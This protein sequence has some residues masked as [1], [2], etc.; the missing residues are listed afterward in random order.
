VAVIISGYP[1]YGNSHEVQ[2]HF[3][4]RLHVDV[5][6]TNMRLHDLEPRCLALDVLSIELQ[7]AI[8]I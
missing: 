2:I 8:E 4:E 3:N 1:R 7:F 5:S 6:S